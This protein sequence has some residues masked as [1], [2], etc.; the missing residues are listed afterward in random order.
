MATVEECDIY[1]NSNLSHVT[2]PEINYQRLQ[3]ENPETIKGV[4][5]DI[6]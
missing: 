6:S 1:L 4:L 5:R 3:P 2:F